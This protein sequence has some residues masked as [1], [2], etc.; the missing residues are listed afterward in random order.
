MKIFDPD[1]H[2][3]AKNIHSLKRYTNRTLNWNRIELND[4]RDVHYCLSDG[5]KMTLAERFMNE[6]LE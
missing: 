3:I 4:T 5:V 1:I 6:Y 2:Y